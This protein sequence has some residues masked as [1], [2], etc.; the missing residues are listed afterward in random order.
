MK[1]VQATAHSEKGSRSLISPLRIAVV[2]EAVQMKTP[3]R[4]PIPSTRP[5]HALG[6]C[7]GTMVPLL[8]EHR[9]PYPI[10]DETTHIHFTPHLHLFMFARLD[11]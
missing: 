4:I 6:R 9:R 5:V 3:T 10:R 2:E 11:R 1:V 7:Y 8:M